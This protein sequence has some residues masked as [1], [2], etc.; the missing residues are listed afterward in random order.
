VGH[1]RE[2]S[3]KFRFTHEFQVKFSRAAL[4]TMREELFPFIGRVT[5]DQK[6]RLEAE[7]AA[8]ESR[9]SDVLTALTDPFVYHRVCLIVVEKTT[10]EATKRRIAK[11][12]QDAVRRTH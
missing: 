7:W 9:R 8:L 11:A 2:D 10:Q 1:L 6:R 5:R 4:Q 12:W 3:L